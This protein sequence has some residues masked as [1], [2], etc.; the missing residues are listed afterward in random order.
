[1][2]F[3]M[4]ITS[5]KVFHTPVLIHWNT[6][7]D[8]GCP[9]DNPCS[10]KA[11]VHIFDLPVHARLFI[12]V[13]LFVLFKNLLRLLSDI[14][15]SYGETNVVFLKGALPWAFLTGLSSCFATVL[16]VSQIYWLHLALSSLHSLYVRWL[17]VAHFWHWFS[18]LPFLSFFEVF[19][20]TCLEKYCLQWEKRPQLT[21][22]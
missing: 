11:C 17:E 20:T 7:L 13:R 10:P 18:L 5:V 8:H 21:F 12:F 22:S 1:M 2:T 6:V 9:G 19:N 4:L 14:F 15:L 16:K 3:H